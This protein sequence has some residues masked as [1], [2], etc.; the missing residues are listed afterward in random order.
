MNQNYP[1][2]PHEPV[3]F[4]SDSGSKN[5]IAMHYVVNVFWIVLAVILL[6][7]GGIIQP[8]L[9]HLVTIIYLIAGPGY[10]S[11]YFA[12]GLLPALIS[13]VFLFI[14]AFIWLS[15]RLF[16]LAA[17]IYCLVRNIQKSR[18]MLVIMPKMISGTDEKGHAFTI[19]VS[20][21]RDVSVITNKWMVQ[22]NPANADTLCI[23]TISGTLKLTG[24]RLARRAASLIYQLT[25]SPEKAD[26]TN[27]PQTPNVHSTN[28][29]S[30]S[31]MPDLPVEA[32]VQSATVRHEAA[33]PSWPDIPA[34][35][36][37]YRRN[38]FAGTQSGKPIAPIPPVPGNSRDAEKMKN[39]QNPASGAIQRPEN[40]GKDEQPVLQRKAFR[41]PQL[42]P[43]SLH[44][45]E[46]SANESVIEERFD[47]EEDHDETVP[48]A[49][50]NDTDKL[51]EKD[52][53]CE[54][55]AL[56]TSIPEDNAV[57]EA[58]SIEVLDTSE[59]ADN[60]PATVD[61]SAVIELEEFDDS[62][63]ETVPLANSAE[64]ASDQD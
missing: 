16:M 2:T 42:E 61:E 59:E 36:E 35:P 63:E 33:M 64:N 12:H 17:G 23:E 9:R 32:Q 24:I 51:I 6:L 57:C 4:Y 47:F 49:K 11:Y 52:E 45:S 53:P 38:A 54:V 46:F 44:P 14:W 62:S 55:S 20:Q 5:K 13:E 29:T 60:T 25:H 34:A 43:E 18:E 50:K 26:F 40:A 8:I 31:G 21:I 58:L 39:S 19:P 41:F 15:I 30:A 22:I 48:L 1:H 7:S 56:Q 10:A 28:S 37:D 3:L 27:A